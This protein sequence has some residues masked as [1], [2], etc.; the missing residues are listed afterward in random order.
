M[1]YVIPELHV[2]REVM[3]RIDNAD[4]RYAGATLKP[5]AM[6]YDAATR[7]YTESDVLDALFENVTLD[8]DSIAYATIQAASMTVPAQD[9]DIGGGTIVTIPSQ[10]INTAGPYFVPKAK[11][12]VLSW[13]VVALPTDATLKFS[14]VTACAS[15]I[16]KAGGFDI[17]THV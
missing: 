13:K 7:T 5:S 6:L 8:E 17:P 4:V 1:M 9:V 15:I 14:G 16:A 12:L 2:L 11:T 10:T 3:V